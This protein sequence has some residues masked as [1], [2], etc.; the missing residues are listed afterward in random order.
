MACPIMMMWAY[1]QA[2]ATPSSSG[3]ALDFGPHHGAVLTGF[4]EANP[5]VMDHAA[6]RWITSGIPTPGAPLEALTDGMDA[7]TFAVHLTAGTWH[8]RIMQGWDAPKERQFASKVPYGIRRD[9][10]IVVETRPIE[11]PERFFASTDYAAN[12]W[13]VFREGET[14]WHRQVRPHNTWQSAELTVEETGWVPLHAY[15]RPL[16]ALVLAPDA[17][18]ADELVLASDAARAEDFATHHVA[19]LLPTPSTQ[20]TSGLVPAGWAEFP[21]ARQTASS[22][23][24]A[25]GERTGRSFWWMPGGEDASVTVTGLDGLEVSLFEVGWADAMGPPGGPLRARPMW[26]VPTEGPLRGGQGMPVGMGIVVDVPATASPGTYRGTLRYRDARDLAEVPL[27]VRVLP[28]ALDPAPVPIGLSVQPNETLTLRWGWGHDRVLQQFDDVLELLADRGFTALDLR[29]AQWPAH[30][31]TPGEPFDDTVLRHALTRWSDLGGEVFMWSDMKYPLRPTAYYR[32]TGPVLPA[33]WRPLLDEMFDVLSGWDRMVVGVPLY[34]EEGWKDLG[35]L[36]RARRFAEQVRAMA[37]D[38]VLLMSNFG[39]PAS[40]SLS[41]VYDIPKVSAM[42]APSRAHLTWLRE[43]GT[44]PAVYNLAAGRHGPVTAWAV[45]ASSMVQWNFSP[46]KGDPFH[47]V[48]YRPDRAFGALTPHGET[49][50][51]VLLERFAEGVTDTRYLATLERWCATIPDDGP[52]AAVRTR[53]QARTF[54]ASVRSAAED[55]IPLDQFDAELMDP[56]ALE[57]IRTQA[58]F[59]LRRLSH[60]ID[61]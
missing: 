23:W 49:W 8:I 61:T 26:M 1:S 31:G 59:Y 44:D 4:A 41:D 10:E 3:L 53:D 22:W 19:A 38:D 15:G 46:S 56:E 45:E 7:P 12:P 51:T 52:R 9:D 42:P 30:Y 14:A 36:P 24:A 57:D 29:H 47:K 6:A 18:S 37:P 13:P 35:V 16:Q 43:R 25:Q 2:S 55:A 11:D 28:F 50:A 34:E 58:V 27:V 60:W 5:S 20:P 54:L 39:H 40:W 48:S 17:T 21:E 33:A 32:D